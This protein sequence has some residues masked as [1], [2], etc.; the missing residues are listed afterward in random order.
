[1]FV[2]YGWIMAGALYLIGILV[3]IFDILRLRSAHKSAQII[4]PPVQNIATVRPV[5]NIETVHP[6]AQNIRIESQVQNVE[7]ASRL[8]PSL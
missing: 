6:V 1:M 8:Y 3:V 4:Y 5:Q 7:I 2:V